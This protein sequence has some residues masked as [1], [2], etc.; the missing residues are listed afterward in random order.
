[1]NITDPL[2]SDPESVNTGETLTV[3]F[4]FTKFGS[5]ITSNVDVM[6]ITIGGETC[7]ILTS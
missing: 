7:T 6:N 2:E 1:M 3:A 4:N 5:P